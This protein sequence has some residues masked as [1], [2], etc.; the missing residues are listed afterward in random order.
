MGWNDTRGP[1]CLFCNSHVSNPHSFARSGKKYPVRVSTASMSSFS[2]GAS[3]ARR[4]PRSMIARRGSFD[5]RSRSTLNPCATVHAASCLQ[6]APYYTSHLAPDRPAPDRSSPLAQLE[7][8]PVRPDKDGSTD[9]DQRPEGRPSV[10]AGLVGEPAHPQVLFR[11]RVRDLWRSV[12]THLSLSLSRQWECA[13]IL[14]RQV[15]R[16]STTM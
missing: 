9:V 10:R 15:S 3:A 13:D 7:C 6:F 16:V 4:L 11:P 5:C 1:P 12:P 8:S 14:T 2:R